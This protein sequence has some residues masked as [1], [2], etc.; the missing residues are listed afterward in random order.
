MELD[1]RAYRNIERMFFDAIQRA[2]LC[3]QHYRS[4]GHPADRI[5][6]IQA[7]GEA[8]GIRNIIRQATSDFAEV[9]QAMYDLD[10]QYDSLKYRE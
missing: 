5:D 9:A 8:S 2:N 1:D 3:I 6:A 10:Q 7:I 4:T